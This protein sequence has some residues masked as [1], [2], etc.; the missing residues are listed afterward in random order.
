M[1]LA[2]DIGGTKT[3]LALVDPAVGVT[4]PVSE[5]RF[6]SK[7]YD[8]LDKIVSEFLA[9]TEIK[10]TA[11]SFGIAGRVSGRQVQTTNLPWLVD[12]DVLCRDFEI[13]EVHLLND[14]QAVATA[15]PHLE[16]DEVSVLNKGQRDP[17]GIVGLI[18]PGT[19]LGCRNRQI[20]RKL[21]ASH[22]VLI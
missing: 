19:G 2:G 12:A 15:I 21:L 1:I 17:E 14:L 13:P 8:S 3:V 9:K 5:E 7:D 16:A 10:P 18:A 4:Q 20:D 11:A 6:P 22:S